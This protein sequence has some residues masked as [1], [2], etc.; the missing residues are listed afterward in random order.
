MVTNAVKWS[1]YVSVTIKKIINLITVG[2]YDSEYSREFEKVMSFSSSSSV[3]L[4]HL[5]MSKL[6]KMLSDI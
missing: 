2:I 3:V 1:D 4:N 5:H 6:T